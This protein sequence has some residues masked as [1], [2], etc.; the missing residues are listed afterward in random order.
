[1]SVARAGAKGKPRR[2][3][4]AARRG[5][6]G[7]AAAGPSTAVVDR[8]INVADFEA[9]ARKRM[10]R[11]YYDYYAGGSEDER[12]LSRNRGGF[13]RYVFLPRVL[14]DVGRVETRTAVLG[15]P[16]SMPVL[17]APTAY[18]RLAHPD[19]EIATARAAGAAG[20]LFVASTLATRSLATK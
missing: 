17:I 3:R 2:A 14:T 8:C 1:M 9:L 15:A 6:R 4:P 20:T 10:P 18:H 13:D 11:A 12:T 5:A 19:G 7:S 16:V